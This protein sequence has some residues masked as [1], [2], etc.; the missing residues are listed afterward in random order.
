MS[1]RRKSNA[2]NGSLIV[3]H[4]LFLFSSRIPISHGSN[5]LS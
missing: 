4:A 1:K 5:S 2:E 3:Y